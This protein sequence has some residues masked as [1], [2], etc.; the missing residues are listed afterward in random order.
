MNGTTKF[1][2][3]AVGTSLMAM[4]SHSA[5]GLGQGF[6]TSLESKAN[7]AIAAQGTVA[8]V[9]AAAV[10]EPS[11]Q[12]VII[13]SGAADEGDRAKLIALVKA[14][15]GVKDVRWAEADGAAATAAINT[16]QTPAT[17]EA[18]KNCQADVDSVIKG[19][20]VLFDSGAATIKAESIPLIDALV[21]ELGQCAGTTVEVAGHT[22]A[23]GSPARNQTL[24]ETRAN[25]V[26]AELVNRGVPAGR[27]LPKGYGSSR[28][29]QQGSDPAANAANRRIEF[30]VASA[31]APAAE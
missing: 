14:I 6:V 24:S 19:K 22:D 15:P 9:T 29:V 31:A 13:L 2:I 8:G 7:A 1:I 11:L 5:F 21:G 16:D 25:A 28:P 4:A 26:V 10:T 20:T 18:V 23:T 3:G 17:A 12:R 30:A 27:L